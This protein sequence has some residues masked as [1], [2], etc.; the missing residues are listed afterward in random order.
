MFES[1]HHFS[2][3]WRRELS[4]LEGIPGAFWFTLMDT[5]KEKLCR[6]HHN[7]FCI[8]NIVLEIILEAHLN[9]Q[10]WIIMASF[11]KAESLTKDQVTNG[12]TQKQG[13][14]LFKMSTQFVS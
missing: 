1:E 7:S 9:L 13:K 6:K 14:N 4:C 8:N 5:S 11:E 10:G 2:H 12:H 3:I